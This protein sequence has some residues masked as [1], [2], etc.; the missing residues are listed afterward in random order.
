MT[1][2]GPLFRFEGYAFVFST[3]LAPAY[4][5]MVEG[6][7]RQTTEARRLMM[8]LRKLAICAAVTAAVTLSAQAQMPQERAVE[9]AIASL[10]WQLGPK[11]HT[12]PSSNAVIQTQHDEAF[13]QGADAHEFARLSEGHTGFQPDAVV[14]KFDGPLAESFVMYSY[15]DLGYVKMDD[16]EEFIDPSYILKEIRKNTEEANKNRAAGYPALYVD[17]WVE[18]PYLDRENAIVYWAIKGHAQEG[19]QFVNAKAIKL[20]RKGMSDLVWVGSPDQFQDASRNLQPALEA[21]R[22]DDGFRYADFRPG[23]DTVAAVGV[24]AISYKMLTGSNKRGAAAVGAGIVAVV[25]AL[26]KKLWILLLF[27][28]VFAWKAIKRLFARDPLT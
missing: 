21:Y 27:P 12:L 3:C 18:K 15:S 24:G 5:L 9:E 14:I 2:P 17:D 23:V 1:E 28:F 16:W 10:G 25:A 6:R 8:T 22:Y 4:R 20:G 7:R 13:L 26:A 11:S 19:S